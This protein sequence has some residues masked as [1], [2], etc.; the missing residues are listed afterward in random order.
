MILGVGILAG[1]YPAFYLSAFKPVSVL[2]GGKGTVGGGSLP[3][4]VLVTIQFG[5]SMCLILATVVIYQQI[6]H[7]RDRDMGYNADN[8]LIVGM[9]NDIQKNYKP[10]K[11]ALLQTGVVESVTKSNSPITK[12]DSW[13]PIGWPGKPEDQQYFFSFSATEFDYVKTMGLKL[14]YGRDF[15]EDFK[16]DSTGAIINKAAME[17]I[18]LKDPIG[19]R[20]DNGS[21]QLHI[22]GVVDNTISGDPAEIPGP[23]IVTFAP[24]WAGAVTIRLTPGGSIND[25]LKKVEAVFKTYSLAYPFEF[26]F[27]DDEFQR[28]FTTINLTS[29]L[30]SIFAML[31][32]I[33]TGL[34]LFGLA[35]FTATQRTREMGI[36]KVM[37]ASV[38]QLVRLVTTDFSRLVVIA[39]VLASPL[40]W[41]LI[42]NYLQQY[43]IASMCSGGSS[44]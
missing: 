16:S 19:A 35:A 24:D 34:G 18:G 3:R 31:T 21:H 36:R 10:I 44:R 42:N 8:M 9:S 39:F 14:L 1:S 6:Q 11:T 26:K 22:I 38:Q 7:V 33:I 20:V 30:A 13:S 5:F 40:A 12:L 27:A 28:K 25:E 32:L 2:K 43:A 41:W 37:G 15:S 23:G 4:K 29:R 17:L